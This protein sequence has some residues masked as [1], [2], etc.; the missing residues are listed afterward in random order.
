[1]PVRS[2]EAT[3]RHVAGTV[4]VDLHG[5]IDALA[6]GALDEAYARASGLGGQ[7]LLLNFADVDYINSTGIALIVAMLAQARRDGRRL[8][9]YGLSDHY[10]KIF[11]ITRLTEY[12][13]LCDDESSAVGQA[14][15]A[16]N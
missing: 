1:M 8:V 12:L 10:T 5:E 4:I 15:S 16:A 13:T 3:L 14:Q 11:R 9:V 7:T 2:L 6:E